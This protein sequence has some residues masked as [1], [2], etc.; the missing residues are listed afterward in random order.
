[1]IGHK[2]QCTI[3]VLFKESGQAILEMGSFGGVTEVQKADDLCRGSS[4]PNI[5]IYHSSITPHAFQ[6]S[7]CNDHTSPLCARLLPEI[8]KAMCDSRRQVCGCH[9]QEVSSPGRKILYQL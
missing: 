9:S 4:I 6:D 2:P 5:A 3:S 8:V 7:S 1:M